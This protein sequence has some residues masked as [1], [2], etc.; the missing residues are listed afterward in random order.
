[1]VSVEARQAAWIRRIA[2]GPTYSRASQYPASAAYDSPLTAAKLGAAL[3]ATGF[4]K[5]PV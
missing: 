3:T 1:M 2:Y 5:G 4:I